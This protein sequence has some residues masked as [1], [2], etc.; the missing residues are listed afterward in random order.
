MVVIGGVVALAV[1]LPSRN[2]PLSQS[3]VTLFGEVWD[4]QTTTALWRIHSKSVHGTIPSEIRL[5]TQLEEL[6]L[7]SNSLSGPIPSTLGLLTKLSALNLGDN[8][9]YIR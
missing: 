7:R 2:A 4:I 9:P 5:L 1:K 6:V 3:S 8:A